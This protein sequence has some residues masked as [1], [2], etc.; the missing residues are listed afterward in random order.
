MDQAQE[1]F[2]KLQS[3]KN[4]EEFLEY[5]N[6]ILGAVERIHVDFKEKHD[7]RNPKLEDDDKKN[8]AK[9]V[10]GFANSGGSVLIWGIEDVFISLVEVRKRELVIRKRDRSIR[11]VTYL[12]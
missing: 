8:L 5:C 12:D 4:S 10:S 7:R 3:L 2:E 9:A 6:Q 1:L 11:R